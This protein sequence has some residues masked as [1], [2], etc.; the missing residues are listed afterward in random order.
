MI[1]FKI[2]C[3]NMTKLEHINSIKISE[4]QN[5]FFDGSQVKDCTIPTNA[6]YHA[7]VNGYSC[8]SDFILFRIFVRESSREIMTAITEIVLVFCI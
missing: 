5:H 4:Q 6:T 8:E 1:H 3:T 7:Y 2:L